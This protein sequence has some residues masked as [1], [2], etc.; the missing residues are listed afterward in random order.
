ML[1]V[2]CAG[3]PLRNRTKRWQSDVPCAALAPKLTQAPLLRQLVDGCI[4]LLDRAH[5][6]RLTPA[7]RQL[8]SSVSKLQE[9]AAYTTVAP[10]QGCN[11]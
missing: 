3:R 10:V 8:G 11:C 6:D 5:R 2:W 7:P 9:Q 1:V 4:G